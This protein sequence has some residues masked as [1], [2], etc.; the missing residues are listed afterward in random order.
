MK[1]LKGFAKLGLV[2]AITATLAACGS[3]D[4]PAK[5][6]MRAAV[7]KSMQLEFKQMTEIARLAGDETAATAKMPT[8]EKISTKD[9]E[10]F[11]EG[12]Y[13]CAVERTMNHAGKTETDTRFYY[14][15]KNEAGDWTFIY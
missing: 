15:H 7:E 3:G 14:F 4:N 1:A 12:I 13:R 5:D 9:C 8:L 6:Q 2:F 10:A 11:D